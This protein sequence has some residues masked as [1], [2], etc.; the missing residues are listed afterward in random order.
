MLHFSAILLLQEECGSTRQ[1]LLLLVLLQQGRE[2]E[3][4]KLDH[5]YDASLI[6]RG[7]SKLPR[8]LVLCAAGSCFPNFVCVFLY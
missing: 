4:V 6:V 2:I 7:S 8:Y 5:T 3:L 1:L